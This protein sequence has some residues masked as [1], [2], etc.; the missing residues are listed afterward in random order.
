MR[1]STL[2]RYILL[3]SLNG[4]RKKIGRRQLLRFYRDQPK[5][6]SAKDQQDALTKSLERMMDKGLLIGYGRR[7][8]QKWFIDEI[9]LTPE[10]RRNAKKLLGEQQKLPLRQVVE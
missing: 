2:Q 8:P 5:V 4:R 9:A 6:P 7:T 3:E 10:G 1:L